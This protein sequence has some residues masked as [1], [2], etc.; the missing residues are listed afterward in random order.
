MESLIFFGMNKVFRE[1]TSNMIKFLEKR[2][3]VQ[4]KIFKVQYNYNKNLLEMEMD[5]EQ[6]V[7]HENQNR[8]QQ[9]Q[10]YQQYLQS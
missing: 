9:D 7:V 10:R 8:N 2:L 6:K 5:E 3:E 1:T 4:M